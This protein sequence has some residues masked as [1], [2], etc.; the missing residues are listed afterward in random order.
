MHVSEDLSFCHFPPSSNCMYRSFVSETCIFSGVA[1]GTS[2]SLFVYL[3]YFK[4]FFG[5]L[6]LRLESDGL[7]LAE[8]VSWMFLSQ[9]LLWINSE[10][11]FMPLNSVQIAYTFK[12]RCFSLI[13][14]SRGFGTYI[15]QNFKHHT[16]K[17]KE[18]WQGIF[19]LGLDHFY[20]GD[21]WKSFFWPRACCSYC[22]Q[23]NFFPYY[24]IEDTALNYTFE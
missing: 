18:K 13:H 5:Q 3:G 24:E 12:G 22:F 19:F 6:V 7:D 1:G 9:C 2:K 4:L 8:A 14:S 10:C 17:G 11:I 15:A 20:Q 23:S 21:Y 16:E